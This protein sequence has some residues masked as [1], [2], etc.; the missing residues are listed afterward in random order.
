[1]AAQVAD[2]RRRGRAGGRAEASPK[3]GRPGRARGLR[4]P[5]APRGPFARR[6]RTGLQRLPPAPSARPGASSRGASIAGPRE[7]PPSARPPVSAGPSSP[8]AATR[9]AIRGASPSLSLPRPPAAHGARPGSNCYNL[10]G[11]LAR[12]RGHPGRVRARSRGPGEVLAGGGGRSLTD[13]FRGVPPASRVSRGRRGGKACQFPRPIAGLSG[14]PG[15]GRGLP[16]VYQES[17]AGRAGGR[18][19]VTDAGR[20]Q[21]QVKAASG[22]PRASQL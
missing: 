17:I 20:S 4:T 22:V 21:W 18:G 12:A 11:W 6:V 9:T 14:R 8:G 7:P 19:Y 15:W 10:S 13:N 1:M 5:D 2:A 16:A 3:F